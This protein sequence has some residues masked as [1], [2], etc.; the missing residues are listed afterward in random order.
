MVFC[1]KSHKVSYGYG[2]KIKPRRKK[3]KIGC[4]VDRDRVEL[5]SF[6][7]PQLVNDPHKTIAM[8]ING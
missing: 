8:N 2:L 1:I 6:I 3:K 7:L 4:I 5:H